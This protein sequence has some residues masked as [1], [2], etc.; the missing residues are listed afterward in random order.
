MSKLTLY[1]EWLKKIASLRTQLLEMAN[2]RNL[3]I[4]INDVRGELRDGIMESLGLDNLFTR[5]MVSQ[6]NLTVGDDVYVEVHLDIGVATRMVEVVGVMRKFM[7]RYDMKY[8]EIKVKTS[9]YIALRLVLTDG[10]GGASQE[11]G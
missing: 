7:E 9:S 6:I 5:P 8:S 10:Q 1:P 3:V 11:V 4:T 2:P